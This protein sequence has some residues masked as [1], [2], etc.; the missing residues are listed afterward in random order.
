MGAFLGLLFGGGGAGVVALLTGGL[1][2]AHNENLFKEIAFY[3]G[4]R[5]KLEE[6][7]KKGLS[8]SSSQQD[9]EALKFI[10][11][12]YSIVYNVM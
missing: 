8:E 4:V 6:L 10:F 7:Q 2:T 5:K 3:Y 11:N 9:S 1:A 12:C